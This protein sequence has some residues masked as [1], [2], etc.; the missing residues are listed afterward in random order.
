MHFSYAC[1][2]VIVKYSFNKIVFKI[3]NKKMPRRFSLSLASIWVLAMFSVGSH[4]LDSDYDGLPDDWEVQNG[5]DPLNADYLISGTCAIDDTGVV[6]W[7]SKEISE[8]PNLV[9][10]IAISAVS[11]AYVGFSPEQ[12][13]FPSGSSLAFKVLDQQGSNTVY[14]TLVDASGATW[15]GWT[16]SAT[17]TVKDIWT[18]IEFDYS[19]AAQSTV[20]LTQITKVR[21]AQW[22]SG[23]Y[24]FSDVTVVAP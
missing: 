22:N 20:D 13:D 15:S 24:R 3:G 18:T 16:D 4:A 5:R 23:T 19:A 7:G 14:V 8:V 10:P 2:V 12:Q 17:P 21:L 11:E 6:C 1:W 9:N